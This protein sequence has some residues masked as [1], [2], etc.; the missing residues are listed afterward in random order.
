MADDDHERAKQDVRT[1]SGAFQQTMLDEIEAHWRECPPGPLLHGCIELTGWL[2]EQLLMHGG[3][4]SSVI[5]MIDA[6]RAKVVRDAAQV[7]PVS[8]RPH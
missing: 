5:A 6:L 7:A 8:D 2:A 4:A 1:I 3:N